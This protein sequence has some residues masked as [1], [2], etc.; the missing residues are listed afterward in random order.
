[1]PATLENLNVSL[2]SE[3]APFVSPVIASGGR[4]GLRPLKPY[5]TEQLL[6]KLSR[7]PT[8][9]VGQNPDA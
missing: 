8:P 4:P 1:M 3:P 2:P 6:G 5:G 7:Q 9:K